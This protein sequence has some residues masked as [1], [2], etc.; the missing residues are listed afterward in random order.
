MAITLERIVRIGRN[1]LLL[2]ISSGK[3]WVVKIQSI[4][5]PKNFLFSLLSLLL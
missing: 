2:D 3:K 1:L 4:L 5:S